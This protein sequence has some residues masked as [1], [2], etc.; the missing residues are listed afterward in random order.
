MGRLHPSVARRRR[1]GGTVGFAV[2]ATVV[3]GGGESGP[4]RRGQRVAARPGAPSRR[5]DATVELPPSLRSV[6]LPPP[7][8]AALPPGPPGRALRRRRRLL[9]GV[10]LLRARPGSSWPAP[11]GVRGGDAAPT[12]HLHGGQAGGRFASPPAP[13]PPARQR[14]PLPSFGASFRVALARRRRCTWRRPLASAPPR[15]G[16]QGGSG[17]AS[18]PPGPSGPVRRRR[19]VPCEALAGT[20]L[21]VGERESD[22]LTHTLPAVTPPGTPPGRPARPSPSVGTLKGSRPLGVEHER[23]GAGHRQRFAAGRVC[24]PAE[25]RDLIPARGGHRLTVVRSRG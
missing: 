14:R 16:A 18:P 25:M 2:D 9:E 22:G 23:A 11:T 4:G 20:P 13:V 7:P 1:V 10:V 15:E 17:G 8:P 6:A 3:L 19:P 5:V 24:H 12:V 21:A